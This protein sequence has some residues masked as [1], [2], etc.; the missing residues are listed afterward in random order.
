MSLGV[1]AV[2]PLFSIWKVPLAALPA[3]VAAKELRFTV[4]SALSGEQREAIR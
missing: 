1:P 3:T 4:A 2:A